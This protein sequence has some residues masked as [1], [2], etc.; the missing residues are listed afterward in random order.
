MK[1]VWTAAAHAA[2]VVAAL[3][4]AACASSGGTT[5]GGGG[6]SSTDTAA[7]S[8]AAADGTAA[9]ADGA[10]TDTAAAT[11]DGS[12]TTELPKTD[13]AGPD[14]TKDTAVAAAKC[15]PNDQMCM[16]GCAQSACSKESGAC[17]KDPKCTKIG[18]CLQACEKAEL[19]S[20]P[21]A[22]ACGK[23]CLDEAGEAASKAFYAGQVC[24]GEKC[25]TC[26]KGDQNCNAIC[27]SQLCIEQLTACQ[28]DTS[29]TLILDCFTKNKCQDQ[30]CAQGC[31]SKYPTGQA[32]L[33]G[34]LQCGQGSLTACDE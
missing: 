21:T 30:A 7:S 33:M 3:A 24:L 12:A 4:F 18:S 11:G 28:A 27:A 16:S 32:A 34:F 10:T 1:R 2:M 8:D 26:K 22:T 19:P 25:I 14:A 5:G 20:D 23:K 31:I 13:I 17:L 6:G 29:C 15:S 9:K